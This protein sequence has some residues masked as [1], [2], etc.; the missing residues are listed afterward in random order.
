MQPIVAI[1]FNVLTLA[2]RSRA[3]HRRAARSLELPD[4]RAVAGAPPHAAWGRDEAPPH[5]SPH[6]TATDRELPLCAA[7]TAGAPHAPL[8]PIAAPREGLAARLTDRR[9]TGVGEGEEGLKKY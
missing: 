6:I 1:G 7:S 3:P 4:C 2:I 9:A 5:A 8:R